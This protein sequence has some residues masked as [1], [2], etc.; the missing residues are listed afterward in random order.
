LDVSEKNNPESMISTEI[1]V[2]TGADR[3]LTDGIDLIRNKRVGILTNHTGRLSDGRHIVDAVASSGVCT[4]V[5]LYGPEHGI[6]GNNPDGSPIADTRY[7]TANIPVFSLYGSSHRPTKEMLAG[8][9]L[10]ICDIQD[11][12]ARFYTYISTIALAVESAAEQRIPVLILDRPN[13]IRGIACDGPIRTASL[14]S[15][16][17]WMPIPV[18]HGMTV[19]ELTRMWN[20]EGE[21]QDGLRADLQVLP[22]TGWKRSQWYDETGLQWIS[23]SPNMV[24]LDTA[25]IYPG[26]CFVEGT[27]LSEGR[28]T[29]TPFTL[30]GAPWLDPKKVLP[31]L[32]DEYTSGVQ[33]SEEMFTPEEIPGMAADP[34]FKGEQCRGIRI[35]IVDRNL[36]SPVRLGVSVLSALKRTH[37]DAMELRDRRFDI[38]TGTTVIRKMLN[39]GSGPR[40]IVA[41]WQD[42]LTRFAEKRQKYLLYS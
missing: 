23:P 39:G 41:S 4:I 26:L 1:A 37:T 27:S 40:E 18:M 32:N 19:G 16:V 38:L 7:H 20:D 14:R 30:I 2:R 34:K 11:I 13:P 9:E 36:V 31:L 5:A 6:F 8:V 29:K 12:G 15:F 28:G 17:G 3:L 42:E 22:M 25:A 35:R 21:F 10:L 24:D 33:F